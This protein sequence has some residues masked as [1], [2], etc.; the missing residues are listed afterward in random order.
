MGDLL[1]T[2]ALSVPIPR[3]TVGDACSLNTDVITT[4]AES[5]FVGHSVNMYGDIAHGW[6]M[7]NTTATTDDILEHNVNMSED[8][9]QGFN[10]DDNVPADAGDNVGHAY[11]CL[12]TRAHPA[13]KD[14]KGAQRSHS[15]RWK[16][17]VLVPSGPKHPDPSSHSTVKDTK[18][19]RG[20]LAPM[21]NCSD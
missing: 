13:L 1:V 21:R 11:I 19:K 6:S 5:D 12:K 18:W 4:A 14:T 15:P 17:G 3:R 9:A 2:H 10:T 8:I 20:V 16:R 7:D